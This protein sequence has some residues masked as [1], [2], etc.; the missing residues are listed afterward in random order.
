[1]VWWV[2]A[3]LPPVGGVDICPARLPPRSSALGV[4]RDISFGRASTL[5]SVL[6]MYRSHRTGDRVFP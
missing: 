3:L 5:K 4:G 6:A 2:V 1:M